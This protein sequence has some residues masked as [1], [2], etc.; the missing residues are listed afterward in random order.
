MIQSPGVQT[1]KGLRLDSFAVQRRGY[2][3]GTLFSELVIIIIYWV[4]A[5]D[6]RPYK[7]LTGSI[8]LFSCRHQLGGYI[9]IPI[10]QMRKLN[11]KKRGSFLPPVECSDPCPWIPCSKVWHFLT[12]GGE[13]CFGFQQTRG[14][15]D[16][17]LHLPT[18]S[19]KTVS[20]LSPS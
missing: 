19:L 2:L 11:S 4:L 10:L 17:L 16:Q 9:I 18:I 20:S 13:L 14:P 6:Q 12:H 8:L 3:I 15:T 1:G 7:H 5:L